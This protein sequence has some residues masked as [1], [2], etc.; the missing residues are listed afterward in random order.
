MDYARAGTAIRPK[1]GVIGQSIPLAW[2][3]P[4]VKAAYARIY[5]GILW[6]GSIYAQATKA[7]RRKQTKELFISIPSWW[8]I[9]RSALLKNAQKWINKKRQ[10]KNNMQ[11]CRN[12]RIGSTF[13]IRVSWLFRC[14]KFCFFAVLESNGGRWGIWKR[15][16]TD[17]YQEISFL[18]PPI[19]R[20][21]LHVAWTINTMYMIFG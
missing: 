7:E 15:K 20:L 17:S 5:A 16:E 4:G 6:F 19:V 14:S 8:S 21:S 10:Y 2:T 11:N 1:L 3:I 9:D 18:P 12:C 13:P